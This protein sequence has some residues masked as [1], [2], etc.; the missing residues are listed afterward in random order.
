MPALAMIVAIAKNGVIGKAGR[1]PWSYP[2]DRE[3]FRNTTYG[4]AVIMGR[5]T[6]EETGEPLPDRHNI[7][8]SRSADFPAGV[9]RASSL[10]QALDIAWSHDPVPFVIGGA[11]L[12]RAALPR[13]TRA[14]VTEIPESPDGDTFFEL[15]PS[16]FR[17]V[18]ERTG[19]KGERY[20]EYVRAG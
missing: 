19:E 4:H 9:R 10:E 17:L 7:V 16:G 12:F 8:V 18:S 20:L 3:H 15:D 5:R 2:E 11:G 1:L 13:I 6:F 14:F